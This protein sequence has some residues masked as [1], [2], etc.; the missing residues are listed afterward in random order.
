[1]MVSVLEGAHKLVSPSYRQHKKE[2]HANENYKIVKA[3]KFLLY[4]F[5]VFEFTKATLPSP[6][7]GTRYN[8]RQAVGRMFQ[9]T[10]GLNDTARHIWPNP[11]TATQSLGCFSTTG[12]PAD[13]AAW[14]DKNNYRVYVGNSPP[15]GPQMVPLAWQDV[16]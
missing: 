16:A 14:V 1:M 13:V 9:V 2:L 10:V 6:W 15:N 4:G 8:S 5:A 12:D 11:H 7:P 3:G